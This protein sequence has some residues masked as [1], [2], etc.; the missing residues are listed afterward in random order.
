MREHKP[1]LVLSGVNRG[2]N[3][4]EDVSY[5]G[6]VAGAIEGTM[7]N[8]RSVALSQAYNFAD[9]ERVVPY[10]T[11]EALA[12]ALLE[13]ILALPYDSGILV[14]INFPNVTPAEVRGTRVTTQGRMAH[15]LWVEERRDG[16]NFPY[17]WLRFS[18]EEQ[19]A[20]AGTDLDAVRNGFVS[21]TPLQLDMT[22]H[23]A[24]ARLE[25]ALS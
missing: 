19:A 23:A 25:Q 22:A 9:D 8:I 5:S 7:L 6:T 20:E 17:Y 16:R 21:V 12:P 15:G 1:D 18:R 10:E 11:A 2:Q 13:R 24:R 3:V 4:A 14:N